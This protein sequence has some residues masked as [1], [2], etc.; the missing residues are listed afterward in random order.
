MPFSL[1]VYFCSILMQIPFN[2]FPLCGTVFQKCR[3]FGAKKVPASIPIVSSGAVGGGSIKTVS[4]ND[5]II[6][7]PEKKSSLIS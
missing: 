6:T 7:Y 2:S 5:I 4:Q 1:G 3:F